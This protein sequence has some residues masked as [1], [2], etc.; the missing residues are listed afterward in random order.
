MAIDTREKLRSIGRTDILGKLDELDSV[1]EEISSIPARYHK[2]SSD[3]RAAYNL[4][5]YQTGK[6]AESNAISDGV[7]S[8]DMLEELWRKR[9]E[10]LRYAGGN[11]FKSKDLS[12]M[13]TERLE[14]ITRTK[15]EQ[16]L[17]ADETLF[18]PGGEGQSQ[19][20]LSEDLQ[21]L[22][23][24][25]QRAEATGQAFSEVW[26]ENVDLSQ[27]SLASRLS[28]LRYARQIE[29][30]VEGLNQNKIQEILDEEFPL[31]QE[32]NPEN[33]NYDP[34]LAQL[35][36]MAPAEFELGWKALEKGK[37][38]VYFDSEVPVLLEQIN[39]VA[40]ISPEQEQEPLSKEALAMLGS[41][42]I[43]MTGPGALVDVVSG[44][45]GRDIIYESL[46]GEELKLSWWERG[47]YA[48]PLIGKSIFGI[49]R[50][51]KLAR[52][53]SLTAR[54]SGE[55]AKT[56]G[57]EVAKDFLVGDTKRVINAVKA[58]KKAGPVGKIDDILRDIDTGIIHVPAD[59]QALAAILRAVNDNP[60]AF[61]NLGQEAYQ[62]VD[63]G[64]KQIAKLANTT[65]D[66]RAKQYINALVVDALGKQGT[67][68][69][70]AA[71]KALGSTG[72]TKADYLLANTILRDARSAQDPRLSHIEFGKTLEY[73]Q[74][75]T[76]ARKNWYETMMAAQAKKKAEREARA[77]KI[78][79]AKEADLFE[80]SITNDVTNPSKGGKAVTVEEAVAEGAPTTVAPGARMKTADGGDAVIESVDTV[81]DQTVLRLS[82]GETINLS[83][84]KEVDKVEEGVSTATGKPQVI[85][86]KSTNLVDLIDEMEMIVYKPGKSN[87][88]NLRFAGRPDANA[89]KLMKEAGFVWS[90]KMS[91]GG[92]S[93]WFAKRESAE[94][95]DNALGHLVQSKNKRL[96]IEEAFGISP[97][98]L[99]LTVAYIRELDNDFLSVA[100]NFSSKTNDGD[101]MAAIWSAK[102]MS[103]IDVEEAN[104]I[105]RDLGYP[106]TI[107][108]LEMKV[109]PQNKPA[110]IRR[111]KETKSKLEIIDQAIAESDDPEVI[112]NLVDRR[113]DLL[114]K[115]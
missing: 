84:K 115:K 102:N 35:F 103:G 61:D 52:E 63:T 65:G 106:Y 43:G 76:K 113:N 108:D 11:P 27:M 111:T 87:R 81:A 38:P 29:L 93:Q 66:V 4:V 96:T 32:L 60:N 16:M 51:S 18:L 5:A 114:K 91:G 21:G 112:Q 55:L 46:S 72:D 28:M 37:S 97:E 110:S 109:K 44:I 33:P 12:T 95:I 56:L 40:A 19:V 88:I 82:N 42:V 10:T 22:R 34:Q 86:T 58:L 98:E 74:D 48:I 2:E 13:D 47:L 15:I 14:G 36:A 41:A 45:S 24:A 94:A 25:F 30:S 89:A 104:G 50:A 85:N 69:T 71:L 31:P 1:L 83:I 77:E 105:L 62:I 9:Q 8:E 64:I 100:Q 3:G 59:E 20:R 92:F 107:Q 78:K 79:R 101:T 99:D 67:A 26:L 6:K 53:G 57:K 23:R 39:N 80:E 49:S 7:V 73:M 68:K 90:K 54:T 75:Q 17:Q 70:K